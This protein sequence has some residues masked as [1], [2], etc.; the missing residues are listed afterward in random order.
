MRKS[1][2]VNLNENRRFYYQQKITAMSHIPEFGDASS[3]A[4]DLLPAPNFE[5]CDATQNESQS[6]S[7]L[8]YF[9]GAMYL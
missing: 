1:Q 6:N 5:I 7:K 3:T 8:I 2:K 4:G 9:T